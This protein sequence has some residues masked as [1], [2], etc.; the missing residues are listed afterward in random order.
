[1]LKNKEAS[2]VATESANARTTALGGEGEKV[3]EVTGL[4]ENFAKGFQDAVE[5]QKICLSKCKI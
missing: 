4:Y 3:K 5:K 1:M 2:K